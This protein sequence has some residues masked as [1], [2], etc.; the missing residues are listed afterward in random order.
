[1]TILVWPIGKPSF[2]GCANKKIDWKGN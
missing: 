2:G 1:V